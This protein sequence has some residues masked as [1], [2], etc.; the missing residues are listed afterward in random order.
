M[1]EEVNGDRPLV[2]CGFMLRDAQLAGNASRLLVYADIYSFTKDGRDFQMKA[3]EISALL[4]MSTKT[5]MRAIAWLS[6][7]GPWDNL[8]G[9]GEGRHADGQIVHW[10]PRANGQIVH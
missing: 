10:R 9:S 3:N 5:V 8:Q 6:E 4:H 1:T 7:N 2:I